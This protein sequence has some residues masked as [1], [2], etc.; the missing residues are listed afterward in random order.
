MSQGSLLLQHLFED[1]CCEFVLNHGKGRSKRR[2]GQSFRH[3]VIVRGCNTCPRI[4]DSV[5]AHPRGVGYMHGS[6]TAHQRGMGYMCDSVT[7]HPRGMGYMRD[8]VT[9]HPRGMGYIYLR[10]AIYRSKDYCCRS[11]H[12]RCRRKTS[13]FVRGGHDIHPGRCT[14]NILKGGEWIKATA[15]HAN[16]CRA[17]PYG[18]FAR[19]EPGT[20]D[21]KYGGQGP[22]AVHKP[23]CRRFC[24]A[25]HRHIVRGCN[26]CP[27][28]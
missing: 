12:D 2:R 8:S 22:P 23:P 21:H 1:I 16:P 9:A 14:R 27:R 18:G 10:N 20:H 17:L 3:R 24:I 19:P 5:T 26:T 11:D 28:M 25:D 7:A 6:V 13:D 4:C 15:Y